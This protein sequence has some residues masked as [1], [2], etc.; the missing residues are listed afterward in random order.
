MQVEETGNL[1]TENSQSMSESSKES[2]GQDLERGKYAPQVTFEDGSVMYSA[3][4]LEAA[5]YEALLTR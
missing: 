4:E 1:E 5:D 2:G 3:A